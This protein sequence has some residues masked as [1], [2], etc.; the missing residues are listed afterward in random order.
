[1]DSNSGSASTTPDLDLNGLVLS[2][3]PRNP[4]DSLYSSPD[5][6]DSLYPSPDQYLLEDEEVYSSFEETS[7]SH[8]FAEIG[9]TVM[10]GGEKVSLYGPLAAF[11]KL[12]S[13]EQKPSDIAN[14][15]FL[16]VIRKR[17]VDETGVDSNEKTVGLGAENK[18][19]KNEQ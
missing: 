5:P 15:L 10:S 16:P 17:K 13:I 2:S 11:P 7:D 19:K 14:N 1:M 6:N 18:F 4:N 9:A 8:C 12:S 3:P